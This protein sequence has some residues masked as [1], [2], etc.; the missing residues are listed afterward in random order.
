MGSRD[1]SAFWKSRASAPGTP[2]TSNDLPKASFEYEKREEVV[3]DQIFEKCSQSSSRTE[4]F[5]TLL[6][7]PNVDLGL[8]LQMLARTTFS[9][10]G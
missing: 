5:R 8:L 3:E 7:S 1:N 10:L 2:P 9:L 4:R 6:D